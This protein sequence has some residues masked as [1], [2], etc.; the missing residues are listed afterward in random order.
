MDEIKKE[1]EN[2]EKS[3]ERI[4]TLAEGN[5]SLTTNAT[6]IQHF[7]YILKFAYPT[8]EE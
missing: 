2:I 1:I 5:N 7:C 8:F 6:I 3:A 4:K